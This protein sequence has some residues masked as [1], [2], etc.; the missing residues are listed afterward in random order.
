MVGL[1]AATSATIQKIE[2][3]IIGIIILSTDPAA[4]PLA[5]LSMRPIQIPAELRGMSLGDGFDLLL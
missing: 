1:I 5:F 2:I 3:A 4:G